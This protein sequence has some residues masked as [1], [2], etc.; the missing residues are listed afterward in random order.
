[1]PPGGICLELAPVIPATRGVRTMPQVAKA[2]LGDT[3]GITAALLFPTRA[4]KFPSQVAASPNLVVHKAGSVPN[5]DTAR[6]ADEGKDQ[7][8]RGVD[9]NVHEQMH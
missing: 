1:M 9:S 8:G 4:T 2:S 5:S 7:C 6:I 3:T